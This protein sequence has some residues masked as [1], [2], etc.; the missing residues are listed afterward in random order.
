MFQ[1]VSP[2]IIRSSKLYTQ[3]LVYVC[4]QLSS[5]SICSCSK[6]V[7]KPVWHIPVPSVQWINYWWWTDE[8]SETCKVSWQNKSVKLVHLVGFIAKKWVN[9]CWRTNTGTHTTVWE[10]TWLHRVTATKTQKFQSNLWYWIT[11]DNGCLWGIPQ[12]FTVIF[13]EHSFSLFWNKHAQEAT[14][15]TLFVNFVITVAYA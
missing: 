11:A 10:T 4:R 12:L 5:R 7:C 14:M 13:S 8:L 3:H 9:N 6:S 1:A 2:P 15:E